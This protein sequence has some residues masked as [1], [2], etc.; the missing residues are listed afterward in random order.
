MFVMSPPCESGDVPHKRYVR[1]TTN[2]SRFDSQYQ[3]HK[4]SLLDGARSATRPA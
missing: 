4:K 3:R 2:L 1:S